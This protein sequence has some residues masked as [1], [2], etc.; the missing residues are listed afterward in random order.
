MPLLTY[1]V[2]PDNIE[3]HE[4]VENLNYDKIIYSIDS[5]YSDF[6]TY[7]NILYVSCDINFKVISSNLIDYLYLIKYEEELSI[8]KNLELK[9]VDNRKFSSGFIIYYYKKTYKN[10]YY[11]LSPNAIN[12]CLKYNVQNYKFPI[13]TGKM[14]LVKEI[15]ENMKN[16]ENIKYICKILKYSG[17]LNYNIDLSNSIN[18]EFFI[19]NNHL[20][21]FIKFSKIDIFTTLPIEIIKAICILFIICKNLNLSPYKIKIHISELINKDKNLQNVKSKEPYNWPFCEVLEKD[22]IYVFNFY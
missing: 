22:N 5:I 11:N 19:Q 7:K 9:T 15:V 20:S 1:L 4:F 21:L 13:F 3:I 14:H 6:A 8:F 10:M 18:Y 12:K 17:R 2:L 16:I